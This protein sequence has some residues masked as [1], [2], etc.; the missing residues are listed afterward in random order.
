MKKESQNKWIPVPNFEHE[1]EV[2]N[3]GLIRSLD[4]YVKSGSSLRLSK[5]R[6]KGSNVSLNQINMNIPQ[7]DKHEY[8]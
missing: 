8:R 7:F 6:Y 4:R 1:Y 3:S 5:G 2:S